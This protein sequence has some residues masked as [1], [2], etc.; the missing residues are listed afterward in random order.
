MIRVGVLVVTVALAIGLAGC[1]EDPGAGTPP[2]GEPTVGIPTEPTA[3]DPTGG[4]TGPAVD[5]PKVPNPVQ[6]LEKYKQSPCDMLTKAQASALKYDAE[7]GVPADQKEEPECKWRTAT[8]DNFSIFLSADQPLGIAG[9]YQN[10]QQDPEFYTYFEPVDIAGFP[11][12]FA[13]T[14]DDRPNGACGLFVGVTDTQIISLVGTVTRGG[15]GQ[16]DPCGL[17]KKVAEAAV[18]TMSQ[19]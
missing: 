2:G 17:L 16:G 8:R 7:I 3:D 14:Y 11:G 10:K 4:P 19:G 15:P 12:V 6:N 1:S 13:D 5:A 18:K 9:L